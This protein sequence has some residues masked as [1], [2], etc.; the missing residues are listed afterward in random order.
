MEER[1]PRS[2]SI[3]SHFVFNIFMICTQRKYNYVRYHEP[4]IGQSCSAFYFI[5][6]SVTRGSYSC[7]SFTFEELFHIYLQS[8]A[9]TMAKN[10]W[11]TKNE[12]TSNSDQLQKPFKLLVFS[13]SSILSCSIWLYEH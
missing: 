8:M 3:W 1:K 7:F 5:A 6:Q 11:C 2:L 9:V 13:R 4:H 12:Q 10:Q